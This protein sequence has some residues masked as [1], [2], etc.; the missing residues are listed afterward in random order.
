MSKTSNINSDFGYLNVLLNNDTND[1]IVAEYNEPQNQPILTKMQDFQVGVVRLKVP[2]ASVPLMVFIDNGIKPVSDPAYTSDYF[3]GF[4]LGANDTNILTEYVKYEVPSN[5][6]LTTPFSRYIFYYNQFLTCVNLA[7]GRLWDQAVALAG[8]PPWDAI[9]DG[10]PISYSNDEPPFFRLKAESEYL[11]LLTPYI[12][13]RDPASAFYPFNPNGINI[14][15]NKKLFYF[16]SGFSSQLS[17]AGFGGNPNLNY[18]LQIGNYLNGCTTEDCY[19]AYLPNDAFTYNVISQDYPSLFLWQTLTRIIITTTIQIETETVLTR[20]NQ[21]RVNRQEVLTDFEIPQTQIGLREY[22]YFTPE[23]EP[24]WMN[25]KAT[26]W[27]DRFDVR[28]FFQTKDLQIYPIII[29]PSFEASIKLEF[30][31]RKAKEQLQYSVDGSKY[32]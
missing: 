19:I 5:T 17:T 28:F 6:S 4:S 30:K 13:T 27:L 26:G 2:T 32:F 20:D 10:A 21:G 3:I 7:L 16:F 12:A 1:F 23:G 22:I 11:Q 31:R 15:M 18:K 25:F 9:L 14:L 29:P 24:R 8:A